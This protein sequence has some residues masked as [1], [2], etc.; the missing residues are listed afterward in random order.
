MRRLPLLLAAA[1]ALIL[2]P[3]A[4]AQGPGSTILPPGPLAFTEGTGA[5]LAVYSVQLSGANLDY[6]GGGG[7]PAYSPNG[8][9][10]ATTSST[11][12]VY[13]SNANGSGGYKRVASQSGIGLNYGPATWSPNGKQLAYTAD[14]DIWIV[15]ANGSSTR[16]VY[17]QGQWQNEATHPVWSKSGKSIYFIAIN[18]AASAEV[19]VYEVFSVPVSGSG[20]GKPT[21]IQPAI[22]PSTPYWGLTPF[23]LSLSPSGNTLAVTLAQRAVPPP[24]QSAAPYSAFAVGLWPASGDGGV[25]VLP[26][27]SA[28]AWAPNGTQLCANDS[29]GNLDVIN[30][31]GGIVATPVSASANPMACTWVPGAS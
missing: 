2:A 20:A 30:T 19:P 13:V 25:T 28:A 22:P 15:N 17:S 3:A 1:A 24:G 18:Q 5:A 29:S 31:S 7:L 9:Q 14:G 23:S 11:G 10:L 21:A 12:G 27:F 8:K 6:Q 16:R 4:H 26:G